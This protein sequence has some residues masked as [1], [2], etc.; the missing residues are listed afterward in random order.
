MMP[1]PVVHNVPDFMFHRKGTPTHTASQLIL[2]IFK[3]SCRKLKFQERYK[4]KGHKTN[5]LSCTRP[6]HAVK[7][8]RTQLESH[9]TAHLL[10]EGS[11][12]AT[13]EADLK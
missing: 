4:L 3:P 5:E 8:Q 10:T 1:S 6:C 9:P 12:H 13:E 2:N 7:W 11:S